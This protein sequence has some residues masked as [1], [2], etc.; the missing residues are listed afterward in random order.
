[1][2][3]LARDA[4]AVDQSQAGV[5]DADRIAKF[6]REPREEIRLVAVRF[7]NSLLCALLALDVRRG[8]EPP[9][10]SIVVISHGDA[11]AEIPVHGAVGSYQPVGNLVR[12][13]V[14]DS[15]RPGLDRGVPVVRN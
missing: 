15:C 2:S 13:A 12:R 14:A 9:D 11:A 6:V 4:C 3:L 8:P 5:Y 7:A 10:D 1:L